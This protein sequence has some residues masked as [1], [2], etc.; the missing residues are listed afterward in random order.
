MLRGLGRVVESRQ[1]QKTKG[2]CACRLSQQIASGAVGH[3]S[4]GELPS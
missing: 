3:P 2:R 1:Q 4:L